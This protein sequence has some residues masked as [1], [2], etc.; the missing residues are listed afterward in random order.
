VKNPAFALT[1][2]GAAAN[3][4]VT[5]ATASAESGPGDSHEGQQWTI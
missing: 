4:G 3:Q 2:F 5:R 1:G